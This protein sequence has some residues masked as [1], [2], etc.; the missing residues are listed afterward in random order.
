MICQPLIACPL[1]GI[2]VG[3]PEIGLFFGV[4]FQLIWLGNLQIGAAKFPEGNIG[5][6]VTSLAFAYLDEGFESHFPYFFVGAGLN[7]LAIGAW[8]L[9]RPERPLEGS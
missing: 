5:A 9:V 3:R 2:L 4:V 1:W 6:F 7:V 8:L